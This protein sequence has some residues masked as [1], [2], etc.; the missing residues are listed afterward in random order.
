VKSVAS[1]HEKSITSYPTA[2]KMSP[3]PSNIILVAALD[4]SDNQCLTETRPPSSL[5]DSSPCVAGSSTDQA[6]Q[7][8][9]PAIVTNSSTAVYPS[10]FDKF[11]SI[12]PEFTGSKKRFTEALVY[13]EWLRN[14]HQP[15]HRSLCDDFIRVF[16]SEYM[17]WARKQ[18][19]EGKPTMTGWEYYDT[20]VLKPKF[21]YGFI[22]PQNLQDALASLD[23]QY[24]K[25]VREMFN[26]NARKQQQNLPSLDTAM[27]ETSPRP[28]QIQA[29]QSTTDILLP[30]ITPP[31]AQHSLIPQTNPEQ[32]AAEMVVGLE[33][34]SL[35][36]HSSDLRIRADLLENSVPE[37][38]SI[39]Q[40]GTQ[41][42]SPLY[43]E[44]QASAQQ[45]QPSSVK[46]RPIPD[47]VPKA[48]KPFFET[49][50]QLP[51]HNLTESKKSSPI[52]VID[53][54]PSCGPLSE[55]KQRSLPWVSATSS[56][57]IPADSPSR[58]KHNNG[59]YSQAVP[60]ETLDHTRFQTSQKNVE[61]LSVGK[62]M[63]SI[64]NKRPREP[65]PIL[66]D[67]PESR[68]KASPSKYRK[69]TSIETVTGSAR[70]YHRQRNSSGVASSS[71]SRMSSRD[72]GDLPEI[73]HADIV[74]GWLDNVKKSQPG[75]KKKEVR[76]M[77]SFDFGEHLKKN[78]YVSRRKRMSME[79]TS[80]A[81]TPSSTSA[82]ER[83]GSDSWGVNTSGG[84]D[85]KGKV[86]QNEP[87]TQ[88][89]KY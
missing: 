70:E 78:P 37:A 3:G 88:N 57:A 74:G 67:S 49:L 48:K 66:G 40:E 56:R 89:W 22:T 26:Q 11:R 45:L 61:T 75:P 63:P 24:V 84:Y 6:P 13:I 44:I 29:G 54:S 31:S 12:Y 30:T 87:E 38:P 23:S 8:T 53:S 86:K 28:T 79:A 69:M 19:M 59:L 55:Q 73:N 4:S 72:I 62:E 77:L 5:R 82:Q 47:V 52:V 36:I 9:A 71:A 7:L 50:S 32:S 58:S 39:I 10:H 15:L 18:S 51:Q 85:K 2:T 35:E 34:D 16:S 33:E 64:S 81:S 27:S 1:N 21:E 41:S 17:S 65:S 76:K 14:G 25:Q 80:Q 20:N 83:G 46:V 60:I 68:R 42:S 43:T